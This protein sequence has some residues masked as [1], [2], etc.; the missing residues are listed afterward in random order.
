MR[1]P[2]ASYIDHTF[3]KPTTSLADI[4]KISAEAVAFGFAAVCIPPFY[5]RDAKRLTLLSDVK[6]ATVI[7]F[8][9]GYSAIEAK[10]AEIELAIEEGADE[11]DV[12][13]N[14]S[15]LKNKDWSYL[16]ISG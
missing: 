15:A 6:T 9:F 4:E 10:R 12:V 11:L 14:L 3:L 8:P 16:G 1:S 13:I 5:I 2:I 7:G